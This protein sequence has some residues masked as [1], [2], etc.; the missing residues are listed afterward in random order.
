MT[1]PTP[2][3]RN[4]ETRPCKQCGEEIIV[5]KNCYGE[6]VALDNGCELRYTLARNTDDELVAA[7]E[8]THSDHSQTCGKM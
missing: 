4:S 5:T 6:K 2:A 3:I 7:I 1:Q 8:P